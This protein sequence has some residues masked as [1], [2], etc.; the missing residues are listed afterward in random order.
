MTETLTSRNSHESA[1]DMWDAGN[2]PVEQLDHPS[3]TAHPSRD[4]QNPGSYDRMLALLPVTK[5]A[6][7]FEVV[8]APVDQLAPD[9]YVPK[10]QGGITAAQAEAM[11]GMNTD[12]AHTKALK[13]YRSRDYN[14]YVD[15]IASL[16]D[17]EADGTLEGGAFTRKLA[18]EHLRA[19]TQEFLDDRKQAALDLGKVALIFA[20]G[21]GNIGMKAASDK[22]FKMQAKR[23]QKKRMKVVRK[24]AYAENKS[25]DKADLR[26]A[27]APRRAERR[28]N[29]HAATIGHARVMGKLALGR[30]DSAY[31]RGLEVID[32]SAAKSRVESREETERTKHDWNRQV[33]LRESL[34]AID[35]EIQPGRVIGLLRSP[36]AGPY[37]T[38]TSDTE[39]GFLSGILTSDALPGLS[40]SVHYKQLEGGQLFPQLMA[41]TKDGWKKAD[42]LWDKTYE[43]G[44]DIDPS[45]IDQADELLETSESTKLSTDDFAR[46][47][48]QLNFNNKTAPES[49][50]S[51]YRVKREALQRKRRAQA[52][53]NPKESHQDGE[54]AFRISDKRT[55]KQSGQF[56]SKK[57]A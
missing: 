33:K 41:H 3:D 27:D 21:V 15:H 19:D 43:G 37:Q 57:A 36:D 6:G 40:F 49:G 2:T 47:L 31:Q 11:Q 5:S 29:L 51:E 53:T 56:P 52:G 48:D 50:K 9:S 34:K 22:L 35:T 16:A 54:P 42:W 12:A 26:E 14:G 24:E 7:P 44:A 39:A 10:S 13:E 46:L 8:D 55:Y 30:I 38:V 32:P 17:R 4:F 23:S 20:V 28:E 45:L 18:G 25:R 1:D